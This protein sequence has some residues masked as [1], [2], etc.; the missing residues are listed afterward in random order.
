MAAIINENIYATKTLQQ[1]VSPK[2]PQGDPVHERVTWEEAQRILFD[3]IRWK[4][5]PYRL[6]DGMQEYYIK[7]LGLQTA[8]M[9]MADVYS[10]WSATNTVQ[11]I[12][13]HTRDISEM[14]KYLSLGQK[15]RYWYGHRPKNDKESAYR[16]AHLGVMIELHK[17]FTMLHRYASRDIPELPHQVLQR[18]EHMD[19]IDNEINRLVNQLPPHK[20]MG[21]SEGDKG[22]FIT[23]A[24]HARNFSTQ[25]LT[26]MIAKSQA[27]IN[28][29][30]AERRKEDANHITDWIEEILDASMGYKKAHNWT[31]P[32]S[33]APPLP[34]SMWK[35]G[36]YISHPHQ[37]GGHYLK[38][39]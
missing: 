2:W 4:S 12:S 29:K 9:Q 3:D 36:Q 6:Q 31:R 10:V 25:Q 20:D 35:K 19:H 21:L 34:T 8:S 28:Y 1:V 18:V 14:R 7:N 22:R 30:L 39:W 37:M 32:E 24:K 26:H 23:A 11:M 38:D 33:K 15:A 16:D 13:E 27:S 5:H 17:Q